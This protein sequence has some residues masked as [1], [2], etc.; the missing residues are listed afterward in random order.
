MTVNRKRLVFFERF[1]H[2]I[3]NQVLESAD[4]IELVRLELSSPEAENWAEMS[5]ACGYHASGRTEMVDTWLGGE[6]LLA[7]CPN[8]LAMCS[9]GAG[10]DVIDVDACTARGV[11]VCN[12]GGTN[13]EA[14]AEHAIGM[15]LSLSKKIG[16]GNRALMRSA[17]PDRFALLGNDI[18]SKTVGI[19]GL[20]NIGTKTAKFCRAF[21]MD[22]IAYDPYLSAEVIG[23]RGARK[24][25]WPALLAQSDFISVHCPRS[26]ETVG[27]F[28]GAAFAQMKPSAYFINTAR[29]L[30]HSEGALLEAL[31]RQQIAGAGLDVFDEEPPPSD[32]PLL[33]LD[34]VIATPHIAG[35]THEGAREMSRASAE[36]WIDILRGRVP[37][38]LINPE[39]WPLYSDRFEAILGFRPALLP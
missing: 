17:A 10:Y 13:H 26:R 1:F 39:A 22:V 24:V 30:I 35:A 20:G 3:A 27:M 18:Q 28:D 14:V 6:T 16:L 25:D 36:Q 4:D 9:T 31:Q 5:R 8:M 12:Q 32:H 38:R 7:R 33:Q 15:I 19:V 2:P 23:E 34:N 11:I 29:G 37:P 21:D